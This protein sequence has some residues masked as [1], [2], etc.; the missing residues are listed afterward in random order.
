VFFSTRKQ[1]GVTFADRDYFNE[2][3][4]SVIGHDVWIGANV[5]VKDGT[6]INH[7]AI[8]AAGAV[9]TNDVPA[10]A[11]VGG[12]PAKIIRFRFKEDEIE[13]LLQSEWWNWSETELQAAQKAF[14]QEGLDAFFEYVAK[15]S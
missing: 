5:F 12:V 1:S 3:A 2:H 9:V 15:R 4:A 13:R 6:T 7:G 11:I 8:V 14:A 10:Y